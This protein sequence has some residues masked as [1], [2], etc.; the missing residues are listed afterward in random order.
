MQFKV[1][2]D[3]LKFVTMCLDAWKDERLKNGSIKSLLDGKCYENI[4]VMYDE[5][6]EQKSYTIT[7]S[8]F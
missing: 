5:T 6:K 8:S 1:Q 4:S 7:G 2:N 3:Q